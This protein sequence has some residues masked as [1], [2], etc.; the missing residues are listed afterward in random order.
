MLFN[1][2]ILRFFDVTDPDASLIISFS[3]YIRNWAK[4]ARKAPK[5]SRTVRSRKI[6]AK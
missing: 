3:K 2:F 4:K 5:T 1:I 6:T